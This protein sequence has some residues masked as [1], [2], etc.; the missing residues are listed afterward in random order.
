MASSTRPLMDESSSGAT[1]DEEI[2]ASKRFTR[3]QL[4]F[5]IPYGLFNVFR[6]VYILIVGPFFPPEVILIPTYTNKYVHGKFLC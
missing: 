4:T 5:I 6:G 2:S 3:R 1:S